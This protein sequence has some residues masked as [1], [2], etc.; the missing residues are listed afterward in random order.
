MEGTEPSGPP[1]GAQ[2][3]RGRMQG[4]LCSVPHIPGHGSALFTVF[5]RSC[6][7]KKDDCASFVGRT[8]WRRAS[9][10][11]EILVKPKLESLF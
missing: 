4:L 3:T 8:G 6:A 7:Q 9:E 10:E 2:G 1:R 5:I 11:A